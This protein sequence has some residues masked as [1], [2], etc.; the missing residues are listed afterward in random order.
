M[1]R[2]K[3]MDV[4]RIYLDRQARLSHPHGAFDSAMRWHPDQ[5][6]LRDC[7]NM[8]RSPSRAYPHSLMIH[9]RT[10]RHVAALYCKDAKKLAI[11]VKKLQAKDEKEKGE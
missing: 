3:I 1:R 9:C 2:F 5:E 7:C 10:L 4:A 6:E 11:A 8:I